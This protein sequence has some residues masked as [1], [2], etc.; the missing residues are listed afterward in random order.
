M[1][2]VSGNAPVSGHN[3]DPLPFVNTQGNDLDDGDATEMYFSAGSQNRDTAAEDLGTIWNITNNIHPITSFLPLGN[4]QVAHPGGDPE[5]RMRAMTGNKAAETSGILFLAWN[6]HPTYS[7]IPGG[8]AFLAVA[9]QGATGF[10]AGGIEPA[11][12]RRVGLECIGA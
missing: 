6:A 10:R 12:A 7:A 11:L 8:D 3:D 1:T 9:E 2:G 5:T 4:V